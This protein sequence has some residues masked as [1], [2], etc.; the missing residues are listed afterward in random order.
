MDPN[1]ALELARA[2][3]AH[4][5]YG[6]R[7]DDDMKQFDALVNAFEALDQWLSKGGFLP[8]DW[9]KATYEEPKP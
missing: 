3:V 7:G 1:E 9:S 6:E 5:N 8:A 2:A 4:W